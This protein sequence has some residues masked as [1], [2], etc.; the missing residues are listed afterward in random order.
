MRGR[1]RQTDRL[2]CKLQAGPAAE[3]GAPGVEGRAL[4][5]ARVLVPVRPADDQAAAGHVAPVVLPQV[6]ERPVQRPSGEKAT[7]NNQPGERRPRSF[8]RRCLSGALIFD[9]LRPRRAEGDAT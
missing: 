5:Q 6:D 4:V 7:H 1:D 2:T 8:I 3:D 9:R